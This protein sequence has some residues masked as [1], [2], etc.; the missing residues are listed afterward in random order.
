MNLSGDAELREMLENSQENGGFIPWNHRWDHLSLLVWINH[1]PGS[2]HVGKSVIYNRDSHKSN[3]LFRSFPGT[4]LIAF[5]QLLLLHRHKFIS[6]PCL[7]PPLRHGLTVKVWSWTSDA[8]LKLVFFFYLISN[9]LAWQIIVF[10]LPF[11]FLT[12]SVASINNVEKNLPLHTRLVD[13]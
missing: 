13:L 6:Q 10:I 5:I 1:I 9:S 12:E 7:N 4:G 11:L 8:F 3:L 2:F